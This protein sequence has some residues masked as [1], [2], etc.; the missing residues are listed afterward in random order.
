MAG[1]RCPKLPDTQVLS[2]I[3]ESLRSGSYSFPIT[4][5][6]EGLLKGQ[7]RN[8]KRCQSFPRPAPALLYVI[9]WG[10]ASH[11]DTDEM[12]FLISQEYPSTQSLETATASA[13][14]RPIKKRKVFY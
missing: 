7:R 4:K 1:T 5:Q 8:E 10:S 14:G 9:N 11:T 3:A 12:C 2:A 6:P 13:F